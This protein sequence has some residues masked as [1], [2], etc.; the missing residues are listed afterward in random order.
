[1]ETKDN[2]KDLLCIGYKCKMATVRS[3]HHSNFKKKDKPAVSTF[4][5]C[6][7]EQR[8]CFSAMDFYDR[9]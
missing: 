7:T 9:P 6:K 8:E 5:L 3:R 1:M 4:N 2:G